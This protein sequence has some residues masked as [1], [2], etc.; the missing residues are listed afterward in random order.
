MYGQVLLQ[1]NEKI[2]LQNAYEFDRNGEHD[3]NF[4]GIKRESGNGW[5]GYLQHSSINYNYSN[6]HISLGRGNPFYY[7]INQSLLFLKNRSVA[8]WINQR[9][10]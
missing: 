8:P 4:F 1:F 7:N 3:K 9:K 5:V 6:G 10:Y 2:Q